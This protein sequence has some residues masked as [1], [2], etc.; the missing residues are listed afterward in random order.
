MIFLEWLKTG[1]VFLVMICVL[2]AAH[3]YGHYLF[4]R[5]FGMGIEEF[6]IG[7]GRKP[8]WIWMRKKH[9]LPVSPAEGI[10]MTERQESGE[11]DD[12]EGVS[13]K[14]FEALEPSSGLTQP[15]T[16]VE[17]RDGVPSVVEEE[18]IYTIRPWPIGG[19]VRIRGMLPEEDGSEIKVATG[20]YSKSPLQ[21]IVVLFAGP[22]FSVLAGI[23]IL[24]SLYATEGVKKLTPTIAGVLRNGPADKAG[25]K[26]GDKIVQINGQAIVTFY[27]SATMI[28][29]SG[30]LPLALTFERDHKLST[31]SITGTLDPQPT[32][33]VGPD[34][35]PTGERK[36]Q[37]KIGYAPDRELVRIGTAEA[38]QMAFQT[39]VTV[40]RELGMLFQHKVKVEDE[41]GGPI[42]MVMSTKEAAE[43]GIYMIVLLAGALSISVGIFNLLPIHPLD[44]GQIVVA[45]AEFLRGGK[46]LS[47]RV[48]NAV[49]GLGLLVLTLMVAGALLLDVGR[50]A[51]ANHAQPPDVISK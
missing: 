19:F 37:Y 6:A 35:Q 34:G 20:F 41:L 26:P 4:A 38:A 40:I 42:F 7:F 23:V 9:R 47:F 24:F 30:G 25:L 28:W 16:V 12:Q 18:T 5:L 13:S 15:P 8:L 17:E 14:L 1:F 50:I 49:A 33:V 22:L 3:E 51:K 43:Q 29:N 2:V 10:A 36:R 48:Q 45:I 32:E 46:R 31:V 39:P 11:S 27:D 21:R 44:G